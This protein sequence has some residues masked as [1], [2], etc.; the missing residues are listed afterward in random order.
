MGILRFER[1]LCKGFRTSFDESVSLVGHPA[2]TNKQTKAIW[3]DWHKHQSENVACGSQR[4]NESFNLDR[5]VNMSQSN[6]WMFVLQQ[7]N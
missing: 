5:V 3:F 1:Q 6:A 7:L 2:Q 4:S